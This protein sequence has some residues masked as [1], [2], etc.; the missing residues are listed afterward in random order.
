MKRYLICFIL[1][2]LACQVNAQDQRRT[3]PLVQELTAENF[4]SEISQGVILVDFCANWCDACRRLAPIIE[5][6]AQEMVGKIRVAKLNVDNYEQ[7]AIEYDISYIP[8]L[9]WFKN[10]QVAK[11]VVGLKD[12]E[13]L[14][15]LTYEVI[16]N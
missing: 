7:L 12:L 11:E 8:T 4:Q 14:R 5:K 2:F 15:R 9:I 3:A 6:L 13:T 16:G 1:V 10:G